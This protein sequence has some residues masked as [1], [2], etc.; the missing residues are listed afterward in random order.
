MSTNSALEPQPEWAPSPPCSL[1]SARVLLLLQVFLSA[2]LLPYHATC[3][4]FSLVLVL[5]LEIRKSYDH[6]S[7]HL[8]N[9]TSK[10]HSPFCI[11]CQQWLVLWSS[12]EK[13]DISCPQ[14]PLGVRCFSPYI[15]LPD[16]DMSSPSDCLNTILELLM[17]E[18]VLLVTMSRTPVDPTHRPPSHWRSLLIHIYLHPFW[19]RL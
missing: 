1:L 13:R 19:A 18:Y 14:W 11:N 8:L 6:W 4:I 2:H 15:I 7:S 16:V 10:P 9:T 12:R 5:L 3:A 17:N